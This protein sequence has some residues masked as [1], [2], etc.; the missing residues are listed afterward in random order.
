MAYKCILH[1]EFT[2]CELTSCVP[3]RSVSPRFDEVYHG[4]TLWQYF[5]PMRTMYIH[6]IY[7]IKHAM[8]LRFAI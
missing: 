7:L 8:Q 5:I 3:M 2:E 6:F 1:C 4:T